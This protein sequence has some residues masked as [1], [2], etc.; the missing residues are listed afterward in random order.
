MIYIIR[1]QEGEPFSNCLN[2]KGL[3]QTK[4]IASHFK[5]MLTNPLKYIHTCTPTG[6]GHARPFQTASMLCTYLN[7]TFSVYAHHDSDDLIQ[8]LFP[9][10]DT[11]IVWH[12][13]EIPFIVERICKRLN[14]PYNHFLWKD[15]EYDTFIRI[16]PIEK[17]MKKSKFFKKLFFWKLINCL[18]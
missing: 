14:I 17:N 16:D 2:R 10:Y 4:V 12:H 18:E 8:D 7:D 11:V 6:F 1:H 13:G 5:N 3:A 9:D 15:D